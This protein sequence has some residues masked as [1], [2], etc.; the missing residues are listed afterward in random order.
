MRLSGSDITAL[1]N[2]TAQYFTQLGAAK[3]E[4]G[5]PYNL[6]GK[7]QKHPLL[8]YSGHIGITGSHRGGLVIT[9]EKA[10]VE[11]LVK[12]VLGSSF[13]SDEDIIPMIAEMANTIAGNARTHFGS[14]FDISVPT[15][16]VGEPEEFKFV[17]ADP[18]L[19][20][21]MSWKGHAANLIIGLT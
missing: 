19:V 11:D 9:C 14:S 3:P 20:I 4:F 15:V 10:V 5:V 7:T 18:T 21:P 8:A 6:D 17:L 2:C 13:E 12:L 16:V 1:L